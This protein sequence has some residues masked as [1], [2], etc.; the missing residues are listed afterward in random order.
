[1][2][3][4][5]GR[6]KRKAKAAQVA[7]SMAGREGDLDLLLAL[8]EKRRALAKALA[9]PAYVV[10]SDRTVLDMVARKPM[11]LDDMGHVHGVGAVKLARY[12]QA[13]LDIIRS[14]GTR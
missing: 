2:L 10:F 11:S 13:F 3:Q 1:M 7:A 8:K 5:G 6:G 4:S 14:A 9:Q 12:G